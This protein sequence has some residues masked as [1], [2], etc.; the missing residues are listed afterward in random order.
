[1]ARD[2]LSPIG[3]LDD[4]HGAVQRVAAPWLGVLWLGLLP[5]RFLQAHFIRELV[6]LGARAGEYGTYLEGLAWALFGTLIPAVYVRAVYV[7]ATLLELQSG[8][9]VGAEALRVPPAPL[10]T[11]MYLALLSEVAFAM[12]A[13]MFVTVPLLA[14]P[15]GLAYAAAARLD[16]PGLI[17]PLGEILRLMSGVKALFGLVFAFTLSLGAVF[18]NL[19]MAF[20]MGLWALDALGGDSLS[21]WELLLRPAHPLFLSFLP[22]DPLMIVICLAGTLLIVE[23]FWLA[24]LSVYVHKAN[25]RQTGEDLRLRFRLLTGAR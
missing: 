12:T 3:I 9:R 22:G 6:H 7:R 14:L 5:Y 1:M 20:R 21:R 16:R 2:L 15:A 4:T 25:Q 17:R 8:A 19:F 11:S 13:W 23:P 18:V 10:L 24:A